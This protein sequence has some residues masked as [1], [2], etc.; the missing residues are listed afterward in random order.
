MAALQVESATV[1][2]IPVLTLA[3]Q[4]AAS[5]PAVIFIP[6]YGGRK[7][8]GLSLGHQLAEAGFFVICFDPWLHGERSE[9]LRER[10]AE[11]AFGGVY[12]PDSGLDIAVV[13]FRVI[14]RCLHDTQ[15]LLRHFA[16]DPRVDVERCGVTGLSMG[17]YASYLIFARV[18]AVQAA[19]PMIGIPQFSRRWHDL[20]DECAF[21]NPDWAAA[22]A[23]LDGPI[24]EHSSL[25]TALDPFEELKQAAPRGLL[26]MNCDFDFDQPKL[27]AVMGY[28]ELQAAYAAQPDQLQLRIYPAG[29]VVTAQMER[30]TVAWF[31]RQ[32]QHG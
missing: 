18:P 21:S 27:Y 7:E 11:P 22:F 9:P 23:R 31:Q 12:P 6:G 10:A 24:R 29:H 2:G 13:F 16:G 15:T 20:L 4:A 28:R 30:D 3:P 14:E 26:M 5:C 1:A 32:L 19:V 8:E 25:I 17:G